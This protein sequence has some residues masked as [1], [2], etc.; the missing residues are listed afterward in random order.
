[1]VKETSSQRI[2]DILSVAIPGQRGINTFFKNSTHR[3]ERLF[4]YSPILIK[5]S[6]ARSPPSQNLCINMLLKEILTIAD[7]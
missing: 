1:M 3:E 4:S 2:V 5:C 6:S 7:A